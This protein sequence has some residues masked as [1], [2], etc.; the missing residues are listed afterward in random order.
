MDEIWKPIPGFGD[1]YEAS[2]LGRIRV[3]ARTVIKPH[4][5]T[6]RPV[7]YRYPAKVLRPSKS[8]KQGHLSV[9][10]AVDGTNYNQS[11]HRLVLL[12]FDG[13]CPEGMEGCHNNGIAWDNRIANLRWDTHAANNGDRKFHGTYLLGEDHKMAKLTEI[14]VREILA[15][16]LHY[17][18]VA[19][20][21]G[22]S[23]TQAHRIC[24][25]QAWKHLNGDSH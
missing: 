8:T 18:E 14:Q 6:G 3:R 23:R 19:V 24:R 7:A 20:R 9:T 15:S 16:S 5:R 1:H 10:L 17:E 22:I 2:S 4:S 12:A 11:V 25:G 13:P 21:Y